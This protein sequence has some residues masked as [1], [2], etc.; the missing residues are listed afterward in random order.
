MAPAALHRL[1]FR[2]EDSPAF[3]AIGSVFVVAA[4]APLALGIALDT[5]VASRRSL[6]SDVGGIAAAALSA[7]VLFGLWY[8][9]PLWRRVTRAS[10]MT[11]ENAE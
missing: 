3:V 10:R 8:A 4:P 2:G 1:S 9:Y 11:R 5:Y 7:L 6:D